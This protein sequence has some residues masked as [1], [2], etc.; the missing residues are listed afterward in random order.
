MLAGRGDGA[1]SG[2][3]LS[4]QG[5]RPGR[6][7][8]PQATPGWPVSLHSPGLTLG[9]DP[10][11]NFPWPPSPSPQ[12]PPGAVRGRRCWISQLQGLGGWP[13]P[14]PPCGAPGSPSRR[15][16]RSPPSSCSRGGS[17]ADSTSSRAAQRRLQPGAPADAP[18]AARAQAA[19]ASSSFH[20]LLQPRLGLGVHGRGLLT[21]SGSP[22]PRTR[23]RRALRR[24]RRH[25]HG[26]RAPPASVPARR[27]GGGARGSAPSPPT[28]APG[29]AGTRGPWQGLPSS[30]RPRSAPASRPGSEIS[31]KTIAVNEDIG[32]AR[33]RAAVAGSAEPRASRRAGVP[34]ARRASASSCESLSRAGGTRA[35][36]W[37]PAGRARQA[38]GGGGGGGRARSRPSSRSGAFLHAIP[39]SLPADALPGV[40][41]AAP[42]SPGSAARHARAGSCTDLDFSVSSGR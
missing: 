24:P 22:T 15:R 29:V 7:L 33:S 40:L 19:A 41:R 21:P 32:G 9:W 27:T 28:A 17:R 23:G 18:R 25:P 39:A 14:Q 10:Q 36:A 4:V 37:G 16:R 34:G 26:A 1:C 12:P 13:S 2:V 20:R 38:G 31:P 30:S 8:L 11:G 42:G 6:R 35:A 3:V 5:G